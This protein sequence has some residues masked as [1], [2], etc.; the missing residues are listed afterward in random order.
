MPVTV[1]CALMMTPGAAG[2]P[3]SGVIISVLQATATASGQPLAVQGSLCQF[4]NSI[5]GVPYVVPIGAP[6][7][8]GAMVDNMPMI[9]M[10]D[11]CPTPPGIVQVL[12]P[13]AAP[14]VN[15]NSG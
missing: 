7:T 4:V 13:P 3:D 5:T 2:P 1:G 9:R 8:P 14:Y 6:L 10:G 15:D 11:M 12:G